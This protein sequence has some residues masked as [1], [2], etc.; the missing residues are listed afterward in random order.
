[1]QQPGI[2][3]TTINDLHITKEDDFK[4][5]YQHTSELKDISVAMGEMCSNL[6]LARSQDSL[7]SSQKVGVKGWESSGIRSMVKIHTTV[8]Y[9]SH[10]IYSLHL[11]WGTATPDNRG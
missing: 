10:V 11:L 1:M 7:T 3:T 6:N 9:K 8:T 4:F 5:V 2:L